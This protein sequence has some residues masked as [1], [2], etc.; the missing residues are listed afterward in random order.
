MSK[1]WERVK[2]L[3][4]EGLKN[5]D[6]MLYDRTEVMLPLY[7]TLTGK[8]QICM[9]NRSAPLDRGAT[10]KPLLWLVNNKNLSVDAGRF[11]GSQKV[12]ILIQEL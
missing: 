2:R 6:G 10:S 7:H 8:V 5:Y 12:S 1:N 3:L 9:L 11:G 4:D